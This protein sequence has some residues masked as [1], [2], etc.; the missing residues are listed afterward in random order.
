METLFE[1]W[2]Q[3]EAQVV[4]KDASAAQREDYRRAY[5]A[6]ALAIRQLVSTATEHDDAGQGVAALLALD[7]EL[8]QFCSDLRFA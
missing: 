7:R 6:G 8:D 1:Q 4:S 5:F 3:H 2:R